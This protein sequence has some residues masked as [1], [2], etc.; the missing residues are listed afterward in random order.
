LNFSRDI[1]KQE[2]ICVKRHYIM[3]H[4]RRKFT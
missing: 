2:Y 4:L 1:L 3:I